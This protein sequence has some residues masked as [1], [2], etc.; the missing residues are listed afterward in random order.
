[1]NE[2]SRLEP[3]MSQTR[4][5]VQMSN[6]DAASSVS[7]PDDP[8]SR[9]DDLAALAPSSGTEMEVDGALAKG[10]EVDL[11]AKRQ[12]GYLL[13]YFSVGLI[14]GGLPATVYGL[15]LGYLNVPN[16]IYATVYTTIT[17]PWS[18]KFVFGAINDCVPLWGY[19]R[20]PY[21]CIGWCMC[22]VMLVFIWSVPLP[23]PYWCRDAKGVYITKVTNP[24]GATSAATPCNAAAATEGGK[25][26][27]L[28]MLAALGY[29][30][31]DVAADGLTVQY[32]RREPAARRGQTQSLA[33]LVRTCGMVVA[34]LLIGLGMNGHEY[35][36]TFSRGCSFN[37]ICLILAV[38]SATMVP[39]SWLYIDE[40]VCAPSER[41]TLRSYLRL[42]FEFLRSKT[43]F[44]VI[45]FNFFTPAIGNISTTA[46]GGV[47]NYWAGVQNLQNQLFTVVGATIFM[48]GLWLVRRYFL[49]HSWRLMMLVTTACLN[50]IDMP[51][52]FCTVFD[53]VRNQYFYL[54][55][56][57]LIEIPAAA[58]FVVSTFVMV[59]LADDGIEGMVYGVFTTTFNLGSPVARA[60]ANQ[61]YALSTPSLSDSANFIADTPAF[62]FVVARSYLLSYGFSLLSL[63]LLP[64]LPSQKEET[65]RRKRLWPKKDRYAFTTLAI[66]GPGLLYSFTLN[67]LTM[68]P[69]TMCLKIAG[70][71][72]CGTPS[73]PPPP[74]GGS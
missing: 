31:A 34:A 3:S 23:E 65:Q 51:F 54:G 36:G 20:K 35:N 67:L 63:A 16:Y 13:Q 43:V 50:L 47:K 46:A 15:M 12:L 14:Y 8:S 30:I 1:M 71:T 66:L 56:T 22:T 64:L 6:H 41:R 38:P 49:N 18:F 59:E 58:N 60:L 2:Q 55:E 37:T 11:F 19:R 33:Y 27:L 39:I 7:S 40:P 9:E 61:L 10:G 4:Q 21:M 25:Y 52:V 5:D 17:F 57:V 70:G 74:Q 69:G 68:F 29:V 73:P 62:R 42:V 28:M 45:L 48:V 32:G 53:V 24:D 26:A 44:F 72:G